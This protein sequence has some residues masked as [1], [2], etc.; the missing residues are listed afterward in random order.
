MQFCFVFVFK[1]VLTGKGANS[2]M[3][4]G[5]TVQRI[6]SVVAIA[7]QGVLLQK[8]WILG[9]E[10]W[11]GIGSAL[12]WWRKR[13]LR[14]L[15]SQLSVV[16]LAEHG[17][18]LSVLAPHWTAPSWDPTTKNELGTHLLDA[19]E[20]QSS[21]SSLLH[22]CNLHQQHRNQE[23]MSLTWKKSGE[24]EENCIPCVESSDK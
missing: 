4:P 12:S 8:Y 9:W 10:L 7:D 5:C 1:G 11:R 17:L 15:L 3:S 19:P 23:K 6:T 20:P 24:G 21:S 16:S 2:G 18:W 14:S 22:V 13:Q